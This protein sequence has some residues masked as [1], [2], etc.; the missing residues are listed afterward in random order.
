MTSCY[1]LKANYTKHLYI[2]FL[3]AILIHAV[4]F[5]LW[6]EYVPKTYRLREVFLPE[7]VDI[8]PE[9]EVPPKP[10][11]IQRP[12][13]PMEIQPSEDADPEATIP[14]TVF[15]PEDPPIELPPL[16]PDERRT[17]IYFETPPELIKGAMPDYPELARKSEMEGIVVVHVTIDK[18]GGVV[19]AWIAKSTAKIFNGPAIEAA[20][21]YRFTPALH[22]EM[23]VK[24][25]IAVTFKFSLTD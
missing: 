12:E 25:T 4:A 16:Q 22:N 19:D 3:T 6:P 8:E 11:E 13:I 7:W 21:R 18:G 14:S 24:A 2:G 10:P 20:Y 9:F 23:P 17:F 15:R 5:A 1:T